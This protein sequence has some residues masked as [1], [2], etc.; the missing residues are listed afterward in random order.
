M[1]GFEVITEDYSSEM[2]VRIT[3]WTGT[4]LNG[5]ALAVHG[6]TMKVAIPE[7]DDTVDFR[8]QGGQWFSEQGE[9]VEIKPR[10]AGDPDGPDSP[11]GLGG[12]A[13][14]C[15]GPDRQQRPA[16]VWVN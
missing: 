5:V 3:T 8:F 2:Q 6:P 14:E 9:P 12:G 11:D 1:A 10:L 4:K 13:G 16:P 15:V 7:C